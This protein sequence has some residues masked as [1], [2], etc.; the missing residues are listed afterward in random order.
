M[1]E[2]IRPPIPA[3]LAHRPVR[4]G[5]AEPDAATLER[6]ARSS[7]V[8]GECLVWTKG[9]DEQGYG[10]VR[11]NGKMMLV[12]RA[13][14]ISRHGL[15]P[16]DKPHVLH[17]CDNPPC[18]RDE[19]LWVGTNADNA[20]DRNNKRRHW[21]ARVTHCPQ[22]HPYD[23]ENT[24]LRNGRRSC[25]TCLRARRVAAGEVRSAAAKAAREARAPKTHCPEGHPLSGDNIGSRKQCR[26]CDADRAR[27][28]RVQAR[29]KAGPTAIEQKRLAVA[30]LFD[31]RHDIVDRVQVRAVSG[32]SWDGVHTLLNH[33]VADGAVIKV[34][35]GLYRAAPGISV[36]AAMVVSGR[37]NEYGN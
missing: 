2:G 17:H 24:Y 33:L 23:E 8:Q 6:L 34:R 25:W 21:Q 10:R 15:P 26:I 14:W 12:H 22:G 19:H 31:G 36:R 13:A 3:S 28:R 20:A 29:Q 37:L 16:E 1:A 18:W 35:H 5:I 9:R 4:G 7:E 30:S 27:Q 11:I 32:L